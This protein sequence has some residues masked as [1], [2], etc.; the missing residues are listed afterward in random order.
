M[1]ELSKIGATKESS[2]QGQRRGCQPSTV[3]MYIQSY[4]EGCSAKITA[5]TSV[6]VQGFK[7]IN[8]VVG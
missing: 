3:Y 2:Q 1:N 6:G 5:N 8:R 4:E 7:W